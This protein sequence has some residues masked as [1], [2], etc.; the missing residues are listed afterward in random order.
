MAQ[1]Y[2]LRETSRTRRY[3]QGLGDEMMSLFL[4]QRETDGSN[5]R[6]GKSQS[7]Q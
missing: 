6:S 1:L 3:V 5:E 2:Q 4:I 7:L